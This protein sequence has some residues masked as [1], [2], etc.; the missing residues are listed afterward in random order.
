MIL[1]LAILN[2]KPGYEQEF[3]AAFRQ[4]SVIIASMKGYG[5]HELQRSLETAGRY[6][7]L[8]EW[9]T[10]EDH[11]TGF[12]GSPPYQEWKVRLH[13]FYDAALV[14]HYEQILLNL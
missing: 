9:E 6:V 10:L 11:V 14:E 8:V 5:W 4:A 13:H 7:L 2:V 3:E 1:E 12:R